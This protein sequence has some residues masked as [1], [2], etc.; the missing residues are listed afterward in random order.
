MRADRLLGFVVVNGLA[1][2]IGAMVAASCATLVYPTVAFRCDPAVGVADACP[3]THYC[4]SDDPA[5]MTGA[6]PKYTGKANI[7]GSEPPLF[8]GNNN[9]LSRSGM[10]VNLLDIP[11]GDGLQEPNAPNCPL[12]CNPTWS[13]AEIDLVCG[14]ARECCQTTAVTANDC[15]EDASGWRP[16]TGQDIPTLTDWSGLAHDTHQDPNGTGCQTHADGARSGPVFESCIGQLAVADQ[17]GFCIVLEP[18]TTCPAD[19]YEN[20]CEL[21]DAGQLPQPD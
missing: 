11:P 1:V 14:E 10:C 16:V 3:E 12:P 7:E 20:V 19:A 5:T 13:R 17:R 9:P 2:G 15:V 21:I 18:G 4:C 8:A 6:L